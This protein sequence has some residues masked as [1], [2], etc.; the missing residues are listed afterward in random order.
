MVLSLT[1][2]G[3]HLSSAADPITPLVDILREAPHL[4][5]PDH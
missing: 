3:D 5:D 1:V 4:T 2:N